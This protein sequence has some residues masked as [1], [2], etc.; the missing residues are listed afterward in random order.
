ME[1]KQHGPK[2]LG[3][4]QPHTQ[5]DSQKNHKTSGKEASGKLS[6]RFACAK[7]C[8]TT[9]YSDGQLSSFGSGIS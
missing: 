1:E 6:L 3:G 4:L 8:P 7:K 9:S 5:T 2:P